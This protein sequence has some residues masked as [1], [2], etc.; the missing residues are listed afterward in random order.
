MSLNPLR[1]PILLTMMLW[2]IP[3]IWV[4]GDENL[5]RG[6]AG[7]PQL[8][9]EF[10]APRAAST[11]PATPQ[12]SDSP[13]ADSAVPRPFVDGGRQPAKS[14]D[15]LQEEQPVPLFVAQA[16]AGVQAEVAGAVE[17]PPVPLELPAVP[18]LQRQAELAV[19]QDG[20]VLELV[21]FRNVP[22]GEVVRSLSD[23]TNLKIA[24]TADASKVE[25]QVYLKHV[26]PMVALDA[27]TK[28]HN[29]FWRADPESEIIRIYTV[30][31]Y[32]ADLATFREE[33]TE[34][35]TLLYPNPLDI[36]FAIRDLYGDRVLIN[37]GGFS[38]ML[39]FQDLIQ[40]F[41]RH[42]IV[43][44]QNSFGFGGGIGG[45]GIGG[46]FGGGGGGIGG[47]F[48]GGLGG[49]GFGMGGMGMGGMGMGMG[50][51]GMGMGMGG[52]GM[53]MGMGGMGGMGMG[54]MRNLQPQPFDPI[55]G[56]TSEEIQRLEQARSRMESDAAR[57][58]IDELLR[59]QRATIFLSV[60]RRQNQLVVRTADQ[61]TM[62]RI[63]E[64]VRQLDVPTPLVLLEVKVLALDLDDGFNSVFDYQYTDGKTTAGQF[65]TGNILPPPADELTGAAR[66]AASL[67]VGG[68][69][70][71]PSSMI[72]QVVSD[73][74]RF[75][76]QLLENKNRVTELA[77]PMLLTAN[78]E[79][80]RIFIG[81]SVPITVGFTPPTVVAGNVT[82]NVTLAGSPVTQLQDIGQ[83][84]IVTPSINADRT[85]TLRMGQQNSRV[86]PN[87]GVIP[88]PTADGG[89]IEQAI[90]V[91]QRASVS[92]TVVAKDGLT[93]AIGGLIEESVGDNRAAVPVVGKM[94]GIGFFFRRQSTGRMRRELVVLIRP[95]VFNTPQESAQLNSEL[96]PELSMHP[97]AVAPVG[98]LDTFG[99]QEVV[100][101]NPPA[102]PLQT[103]FRFHSV[104]PKVY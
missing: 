7:L 17:L 18:P 34:V 20:P 60:I 30:D 9:N 14:A 68:S 69:G 53:G 88:V 29:L 37:P 59:R 47:G 49:G 43:D 79:V 5:P 33:E 89:V 71:D 93:V 13:V 84:L 65:T 99:P 77:T 27:I 80:S 10:L 32:D 48:G 66:R 97:R 90:D 28:S 12:Q 6:P 42:N 64:L 11:L 54:G 3:G 100:R 40:R 38:D 26:T 101:P 61:K 35:F 78:N 67:A 102:S 25:I 58:A 73:S 82:G 96:I 46:G 74:F 95:Y 56:L 1:L 83:S 21:E 62:S 91:V 4:Q 39:I 52:M 19:I 31:E 51:G 44:Q 70:I 15:E 76:I 92:G 36:A 22:L 86:I 57:D 104:E 72:F 2:V 8:Q 75:R 45:G 98:T 24:P 16:E 94:P 87:G 55:E 103:I 50:M 81:Q 41:T 85:V 63:R 23:Q